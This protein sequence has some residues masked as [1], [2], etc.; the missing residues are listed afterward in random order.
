MLLWDK[1]SKVIGKQDVACDI[2]EIQQVNWLKYFT[3]IKSEL[4][5]A[6]IK[7]WGMAAC[8]KLQKCRATHNL[9]VSFGALSCHRQE[10]SNK[11]VYVSIYLFS[12]IYLIILSPCSAA[13]RSS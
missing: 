9:K 6:V 5:S 2:L 10:N 1:S 13:I 11:F 7:E 4:V 8:S 3:R 12:I